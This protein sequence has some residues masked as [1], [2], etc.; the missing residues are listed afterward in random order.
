MGIRWKNM[1]RKILN[2][3]IQLKVGLSKCLTKKKITNILNKGKERTRNISNKIIFFY[4]DISTYKTL[5]H[6][7]SL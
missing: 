2:I 3:I 4:I 1:P 7:A 5:T 6:I